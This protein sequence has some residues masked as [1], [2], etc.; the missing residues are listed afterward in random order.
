MRMY[1]WY[2]GYGRIICRT[3]DRLTSRLWAQLCELVS[4]FIVRGRTK[5]LWRRRIGRLS[6]LYW[7]KYEWTVTMTLSLVVVVV[8][9]KARRV[10]VKL[11]SYLDNCTCH[12]AIAEHPRE[13]WKVGLKEEIG[14]DSSCSL[15]FDWG[16]KES[17][18]AGKW[19]TFDMEDLTNKTDQLEEISVL[20]EKK[21]AE[22]TT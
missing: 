5:L 9:E 1:E 7:R 22:P 6:E 16:R 21:G 15:K 19:L 18:E 10:P 12:L 13:R 17:Q 14:R 4:D 2:E 20:K 3:Q 11:S 8:K